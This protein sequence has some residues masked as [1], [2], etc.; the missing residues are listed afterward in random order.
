MRFA[1]KYQADSIHAK[2]CDNIK[3][4]ENLHIILDVNNV[5]VHNYA[6]IMWHKFLIDFNQTWS[7][8]FT[9]LLCFV[10]W[11]EHAEFLFNLCNPLI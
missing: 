9:K 10:F 2:F 11:A 4:F 3:L 1:R 7:F 5:H 6:I 8:Y